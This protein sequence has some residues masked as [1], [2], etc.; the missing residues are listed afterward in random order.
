LNLAG[1]GVYLNRTSVQSPGRCENTVLEVRQYAH[2]ALRH[3]LVL[4]VTASPANASLPWSGCTVS[5]QWDV[6]GPSP[7]LALTPPRVVGG[8]LVWSGTNLHPEEPWLNTTT[9]GIA[10]DA[11]ATNCTQWVFTPQA[12]VL[13]A[14]VAIFTDVAG[15]DAVAPGAAPADSAAS[16]WANVSAVDA[17]A[18]LG[19]HVGAWATLWASGGVEVAG[20]SSFA[21]ILNGSLYDIVSSLRQDWV[22]S[23]SPGGL[24]TG[25][26]VAC[27][28]LLC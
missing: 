19:T 16:A 11:W 6:F 4:D 13:S 21:A 23:T 10:M 20:N 1:Y 9:V 24:G 28:S 22:F 8:A 3:I 2:R 7:D 27:I 25:G 14:R 15:D 18:L 12:P 5:V 17:E 26:W